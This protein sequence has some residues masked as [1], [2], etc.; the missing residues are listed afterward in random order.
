H[1]YRVLK[2]DHSILGGLWTGIK[3]KE[4]SDRGVVG[5]ELEKRSVDEA[6]SVY[7]AFIVQ[8]AVR[9]VKRPRKQDTALIMYFLYAFVDL[10]AWVLELLPS[11]SINLESTSLRWRLIRLFTSSLRVI[12]GCQR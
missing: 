2:C 12:S 8:E 9:L 4:L 10:A 6:E 1:G 7:S 3:R 5:P 11:R